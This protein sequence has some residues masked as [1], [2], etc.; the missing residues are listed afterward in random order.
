MTTAHKAKAKVKATKEQIA[1][2]RDRA[3]KDNADKMVSFDALSHLRS[4]LHTP[5]LD[6]HM[7]RHYLPSQPGFEP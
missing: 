7:L 2:L 3:N 6:D 1:G 5:A 4:S